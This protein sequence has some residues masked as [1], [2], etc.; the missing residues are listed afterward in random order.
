MNL[1][2]SKNVKS[3]SKGKELKNKIN[4]Q[5]NYN[6]NILESIIGHKLKDQKNK[7][8]YSDL[9]RLTR[10]EKIGAGD[11]DKL[12]TTPIVNE[13][14]GETNTPDIIFKDKVN[15]DSFK[16]RRS[17]LKDQGQYIGSLGIAPRVNPLGKVGRGIGTLIGNIPHKFKVDVTKSEND[18][19]QNLRDDQYVKAMKARGKLHRVGRE[20]E[21]LAKLDV[22]NSIRFQSYY[23]VKVKKYSSIT[24]EL[25]PLIEDHS[26]NYESLSKSDQLFLESL[27]DKLES[28]N[29]DQARQ[30][31]LKNNS[32]VLNIVNKVT[33]DLADNMLCSWFYLGSLSHKY[34]GKYNFPIFSSVN[35]F[36][37]VGN[38]S[39]SD[40]TKMK[41]IDS[42]LLKC[43]SSEDR[44]QVLNYYSKE[45]DDLRDYVRKDYL[46]D[47]IKSELE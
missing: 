46:D 11:L 30:L 19:L 3:T 39:P 27:D 34:T 20:L 29:W 41:K 12:Y 18:G 32:K 37:H 1:T 28:M 24:S 36:K 6:K 44:D 40:I 10:N 35:Y 16:L 43:K 31:Y 26:E 2:S 45:I 8:A 7:Q 42:D 22:Y 5:Y 14:T 9:Y 4:D 33:Y 47:F 38:V 13:N 21:D 25:T 23:P 15:I 17:R